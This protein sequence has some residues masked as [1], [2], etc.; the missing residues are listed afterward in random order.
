VLQFLSDDGQ[1][2]AEG[3]RGVKVR[4]MTLPDAFIDQDK[5]EAMYAEAGLD[6][7]AIVR[8]VFAVLER[9]APRTGLSRG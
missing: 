8:Q 7:A 4:C 3:A 5:P 2:D 1:L 9:E 6:A